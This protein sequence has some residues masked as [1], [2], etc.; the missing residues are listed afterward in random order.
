ML[1]SI[2]IN[3]EGDAPS[4]GT[5]LKLQNIMNA[6]PNL[7]MGL[8]FLT[9]APEYDPLVLLVFTRSQRLNEILK[10]FMELAKHS[11]LIILSFHQGKVDLM[12]L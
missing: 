2:V 11:R 8:N 10:F 6:S 12:L 4:D 1:L 3:I 5:F 7:V 9:K